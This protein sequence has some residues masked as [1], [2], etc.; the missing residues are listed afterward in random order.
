MS[1]QGGNSQA[2]QS[3]IGDIMRVALKKETH[4]QDRLKRTI[5]YSGFGT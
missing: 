2:T 4:E 1:Q 3:Q 5:E